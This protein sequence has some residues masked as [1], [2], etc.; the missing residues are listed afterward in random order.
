MTNTSSEKQALLYFFMLSVGA[1]SKAGI[2]NFRFLFIFV[3]TIPSV[4]PH[5]S[6]EVQPIRE[7]T[8]FPGCPL[9]LIIDNTKH[10]KQNLL[11]KMHI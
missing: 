2:S 6:Q 3:S 10:A 7:V 1:K 4:M 5:I 9:P 11:A 8:F